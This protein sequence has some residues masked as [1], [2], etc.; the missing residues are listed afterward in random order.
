MPLSR[1]SLGYSSSV[2]NAES[3]PRFDF[4]RGRFQ[5][6]KWLLRRV[7]FRDSNNTATGPVTVLAGAL[8]FDKWTHGRLSI[9][10]PDATP[11]EAIS[12]TRWVLEFRLSELARRALPNVPWN[13]IFAV[14]SNTIRPGFDS[15]FAELCLC[16]Y[17]GR[18][19]YIPETVG[20]K[21][22]YDGWCLAI[23]GDTETAERCFKQAIAMV[24]F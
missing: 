13:D 7:R 16:I 14:F 21:Y 6:S 11:G 20:G 2:L 5:Y 12:V 15:L 24:K 22:L 1:L 10:T 9:A 19:E 17:V 18:S 8:D 4:E 3:T 23:L